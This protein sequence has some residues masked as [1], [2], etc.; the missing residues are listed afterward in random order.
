[1]A[2]KTGQTD[3]VGLELLDICHQYGETASL[4]SVSLSVAPGEVLCLLGHSGCGKTTLMRVAAG[5]ERQSKGEVRINGELMAGEGLF[6]P[7]EKRG[8]GL[9]FQDYALFPHMT[10]L[11]NVLFGLKHLAKLEA[12][13][14]AH[15]AL[16]R[17]GLMS[18]AG[19]YPHALSGGEQQRVALAR[20][21]APRPGILL[22]DEP[23]SGLDKRL[24]DTVREETLAILRDSQ[25]SCIVVTHDP[26]EAMR[27]GDKIALMRE[28]RLVQYGAPSDLYRAPVDLATAR[29]FSEL[30]EVPGIVRENGVETPV[31]FLPVPEFF[32]A[33]LSS[34]PAGTHVRVAVRPLGLRLLA[35]TGE[36]GAAAHVV[37]KRFVGEM[38]IVTVSVDG[39]DELLQARLEPGSGLELGQRVCLQA[40]PRETLVFVE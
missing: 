14:R 9:M 8:V 2:S 38:D 5:V 17:V 16:Q 40:H 13:E 39:I 7:P 37:A 18:H 15:A 19:D 23:F 28:G 33:G 29:F 12:L 35:G 24:R 31:G 32:G 22:M 20:A 1:M 6:V 10:I 30:N 3:R 26:E 27:M 21:L 4:Q 11:K 36:E 34:V 25:A